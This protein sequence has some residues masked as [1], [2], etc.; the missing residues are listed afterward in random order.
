MFNT[1]SLP[2]EE[3]QDQT[4]KPLEEAQSQH[5]SASQTK[6]R[7]GDLSDEAAIGFSTFSLRLEEPFYRDW[8]QAVYFQTIPQDLT[9]PFHR[10]AEES[11][12]DL[13]LILNDGDDHHEP[14]NLDASQH[15]VTND[16]AA[17]GS[18]HKQTASPPHTSAMDLLEAV[19]PQIGTDWPDM[20]FAG[21]PRCES[22]RIALIA[23]LQHHPPAHTCGP[24][25]HVSNNDTTCPTE[26]QL[27][28]IKFSPP[29]VTYPAPP[30]GDIFDR[31]EGRRRLNRGRRAK[32]TPQEDSLLIKLKEEESLTWAGIHQ[33]FNRNFPSAAR[34]RATLQV[35]YCTSLKDRET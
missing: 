5:E 27:S 7:L 22:Y 35:H 32:F 15:T 2:T 20:T 17:R 31:A 25:E 29:A 4:T 13:T 9:A 28:P 6:A 23:A 14:D 34:S 11:I 16:G 1:S 24:Q 10:E 12:S 21:C 3:P 8:K 30:S 18:A 33:Q 26:S 19:V